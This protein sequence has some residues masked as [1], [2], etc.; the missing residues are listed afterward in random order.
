MKQE[1]VIQRLNTAAAEA[2]FSPSPQEYAAYVRGENI[3][4][5]KI[6]RESGKTSEEFT[7]YLK[8]EFERMREVVKQSGA[9][10]E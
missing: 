1:Q 6:I 7:Q 2:V 5:G 3:R 10:V 8:A 9:R 4:W